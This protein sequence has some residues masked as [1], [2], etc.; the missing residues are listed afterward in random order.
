MPRVDILADRVRLT[1]TPLMRSRSR[2]ESWHGDGSELA[3][4]WPSAR[5][6][7]LR[8]AFATFMIDA[9]VDVHGMISSGASWPNRG[10]APKKRRRAIHTH[11]RSQI[12]DP[13]HG[14]QCR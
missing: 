5:D 4:A 14:F 13:G 7:S 10:Q 9:S 3:G 12:S 6:A 11:R 1:T 2:R 8:R